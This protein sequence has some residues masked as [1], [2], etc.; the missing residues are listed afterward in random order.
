[1]AFHKVTAA[2]STPLR[3]LPLIPV[4]LTGFQLV[5]TWPWN[6]SSRKSVAQARVEQTGVCSTRLAL[7]LGS[8]GNTNRSCRQSKSPHMFKTQREPAVQIILLR[9]NNT[10][11]ANSSA[12]IRNLI[13]TP[14]LDIW[15]TDH[16]IS[17]PWLVLCLFPPVG[18]KYG[19]IFSKAL[20]SLGVL[21]LEFQGR[22]G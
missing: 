8:G 21:V 16:L 2:V 19:N 1:M 12:V 15:V 3:G 4:D 20:H 9:E 10:E 14:L 5:C 6:C 13:A 22:E 18:S 11:R 17:E 7:V